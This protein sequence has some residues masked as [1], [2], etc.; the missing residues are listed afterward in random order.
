MKRIKVVLDPFKYENDDGYQLT[1]ALVSSFSYLKG[2]KTT[3]IRFILY[4]F[5]ESKTKV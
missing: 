2:S 1:N 5:L 3:F 4:R